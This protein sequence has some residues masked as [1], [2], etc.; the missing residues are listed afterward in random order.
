MIDG[1]P[2]WLSITFY[3]AGGTWVLYS[4]VGRLVKD[5]AKGTG[6][7]TNVN[8]HIES[9]NTALTGLDERVESTNAAV[10]GL[11]E[12]VGTLER[13]IGKMQKDLKR[14]LL[15]V[16]PGYP[17]FESDSPLRLTD[18][19]R[20]VAAELDADAWVQ[21]VIT[22]FRERT[23]GEA[24]YAIEEV[25]FEFLVYG[26]EFQPS[27]DFEAKIRASA[28]E[29]GLTKEQVRGVLALV[30]RDELIRLESASDAVDQPAD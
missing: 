11:G 8:E 9:T 27:P 5:F 7:F 10:S 25:C 15:V 28:Y 29:H 23:R 30:L 22:D 1:V 24:P 2:S 12:R 4:L 17:T 20:D 26:D 16:F 19:G 3:V 6:W 14:A 21:G 18:L 13:V